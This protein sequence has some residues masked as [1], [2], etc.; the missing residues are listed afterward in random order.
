[1]EAP[2]GGWRSHTT[3]D[4]AHRVQAMVGACGCWRSMASTHAAQVRI[5]GTCARH[6][7]PHA[8]PVEKCREGSMRRHSS[9][10]T[11]FLRSSWHSRT[12][13]GASSARFSMAIEK[14]CVF[15]GLYVRDCVELFCGDGGGKALRTLGQR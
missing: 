3:D 9:S 15:S 5:S 2:S 7:C 10:L 14:N 4:G 8:G 12:H 6:A 11:L 1:M 13:A